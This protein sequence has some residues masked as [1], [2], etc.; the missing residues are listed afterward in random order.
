VLVLLYRGSRSSGGVGSWWRH[1]SLVLIGARMVLLLIRG[2][3]LALYWCSRSWPAWSLVW[4]LLWW[5]TLSVDSIRALH[6][7]WRLLRRTGLSNRRC[8]RGRKTIGHIRC[9][10]GFNSFGC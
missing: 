4:P 6:T 5:M 2:L 10:G 1:T 3:W 8:A 9:S 7:R